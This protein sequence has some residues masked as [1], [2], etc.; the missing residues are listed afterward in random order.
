ME[1]QFV[2]LSGNCLTMPSVRKSANPIMWLSFW[3]VA[4]MSAF[5]SPLRQAM[6]MSVINRRWVYIMSCTFLKGQFGFASLNN[7]AI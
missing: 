5:Q 4:A 2:N 1:G 6:T 3:S 7:L